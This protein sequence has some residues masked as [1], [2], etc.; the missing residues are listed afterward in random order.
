MAIGLEPQEFVANAP[1]V[2]VEPVAP[3]KL[4]E[5]AVVVEAPIVTPP[6]MDHK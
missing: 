5:F 1:I 4:A 6:L 2:A 3:V